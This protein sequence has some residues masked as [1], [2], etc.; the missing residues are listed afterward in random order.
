MELATS[1]PDAIAEAMVATLGAPLR[2]K[3]VNAD[4]AARAAR[5][6]ADLI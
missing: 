4:G 5:K 6:L 2:S 3:P 1:T